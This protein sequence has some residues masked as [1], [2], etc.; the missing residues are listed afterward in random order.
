MEAP[1]IYGHP[2][3]VAEGF[4][5]Q[6]GPRCGPI[7]EGRSN[8]EFVFA[9]PDW[10]ARSLTSRGPCTDDENAFG[11]AGQRARRS[12]DGVLRTARLPGRADDRRSDLHLAD[13]KWWVCL[14]GHLYRRASG[15]LAEGRRRGPCQRRPDIAPAL[16]CRSGIAR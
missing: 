10:C 15:G 6:Q 7:D 11:H 1:T 3:A 14:A 12:Y 9:D 8:V 2:I 16:A 4:K 5:R 13:R